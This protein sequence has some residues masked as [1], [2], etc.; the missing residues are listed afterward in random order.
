MQV[1]KHPCAAKDPKD[2][3][4]VL[5]EARPVA[6]V[7]FFLAAGQLTEE[8]MVLIYQPDCPDVYL[9]THHRAVVMTL[10]FKQSVNT[11][12][13]LNNLNT[14]PHHPPRKTRAGRA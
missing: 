7:W 4:P 10:V 2:P 8:E 5:L 3:E 11:P 9:Q 6:T 13:Q 1:R 14:T 12:G